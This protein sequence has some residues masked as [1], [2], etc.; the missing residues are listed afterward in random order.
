MGSAPDLFTQNCLVLPFGDVCL[1]CGWLVI[2]PCDLPYVVVY[3]LVFALCFLVFKIIMLN[4]QRLRQPSHA[5]PIT[6]W[7]IGGINL[8]MVCEPQFFLKGGPGM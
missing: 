2:Y 4:L 7:T 5:R 1:L 3:D 6:W 8:P